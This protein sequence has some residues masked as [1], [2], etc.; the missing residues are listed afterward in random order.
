MAVV[1][2]TRY[3][4]ANGISDAK[5]EGKTDQQ[6]KHNVRHVRRS[7]HRVGKNSLLNDRGAIKFPPTIPG[8]FATLA[9][10]AGSLDQ[11][12]LIK[13]NKSLAEYGRTMNT[14]CELATAK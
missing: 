10:M 1:A 6:P 14:M 8:L 3:S 11:F 13:A 4:L 2:L 5:A 12:V 9:N 7:H